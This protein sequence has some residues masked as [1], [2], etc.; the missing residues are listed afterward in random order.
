MRQVLQSATV[1]TKWDVT[2][3]IIIDSLFSIQHLH[4]SYLHFRKT[5][6]HHTWQTWPFD[7]VVTWSYINNKKQN[8]ST[9]M[10]HM[11]AKLDKGEVYSKGPPSIESFNALITWSSYHVTHEKH[12]I[13][14]FARPMAPKLDRVV[15]SNAGLLSIKSHNLL[16]MWS[17]KITWQMIK[18][19]NSHKIT[20]QMINV[21]NSLSHDLWLSNMTEGGLM[22]SHVQPQRHISLGSRGCGGSCDKWTSLYLYFHEAYC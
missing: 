6:G 14:T 20:W 1:I 10:R 11:T 19:I 18:V 16:I 8:I 2:N 5:Y 15:G 21:I 4:I 12:Y 7:Q 22:E 9:S 17:H 3:V 13:S